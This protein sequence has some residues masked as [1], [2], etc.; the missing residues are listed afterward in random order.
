MNKI[1][2]GMIFLVA[3]AFFAVIV[4]HAQ[5]KRDGQSKEVGKKA[6]PVQ[7]KEKAEPKQI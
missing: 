2:L 3:V 7:S 4:V 6:V 5:S 1:K